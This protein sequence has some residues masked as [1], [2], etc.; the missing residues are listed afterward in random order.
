MPNF[1]IDENAVTFQEGTVPQG[2]IEIPDETLNGTTLLSHPQL[3]S[4]H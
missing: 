3:H 2:V 4:I 1:V